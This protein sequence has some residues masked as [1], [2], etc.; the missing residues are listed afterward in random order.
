MPSSSRIGVVGVQQ[1]GADA[2]ALQVRA[3]GEDGQV[4]VRD[5]GQVVGI[6]FLIKGHEPLGPLTGDL[7]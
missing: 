4:V 2:L 6:Q 3:D 7:G 1:R 5:T